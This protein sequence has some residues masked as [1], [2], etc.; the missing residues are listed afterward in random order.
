MST[1]LKS[2][3]TILFIGDSITDCGRRD[4]GGRPLG[5]GYVRMFRD[6]QVVHEPE[7]KITVINKGIGGNTVE[8]LR[9]RWHDDALACRPEWLSIKIGIND[10]NR[11]L[12]SP[13]RILSPVSYGKIYRQILELTR[14]ALPDTRILLIDPFF[15]S[16]DTTE[17]SYRKK[18]LDIL[19][20]YHE[21]IHA[22]RDEFGTRHVATHDLFQAAL[23]HRH[24]DEFCPEPV[25]PH[26]VGHILIAQAVYKALGQ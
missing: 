12:N 13:E 25:H 5:H 21:Q 24:P 26:E 14:K 19:P 10:L 17:G 22:L 1:L 16:Q 2:G 8:D 4:P 6:F 3:E 20:C 7:K 18:V 23:Q 15:I 9:S 11:H